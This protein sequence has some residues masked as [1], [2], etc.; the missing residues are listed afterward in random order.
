MQVFDRWGSLLFSKKNI[1]PN[2]EK[3]GW[4][5]ISR[6]KIVE[7]GVYTCLLIMEYQ[8]QKFQFS[9]SVTLIR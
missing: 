3:Y 9:Q 2:D 5:G 6:G 7:N 1:A 4:D 8:G